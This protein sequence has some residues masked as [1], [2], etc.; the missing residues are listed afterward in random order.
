MFLKPIPLFIKITTIL[1]VCMRL[2]FNCLPVTEII[3]QALSPAVVQKVVTYV[4]KRMKRGQLTH[5]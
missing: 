1:F 4:A 2:Y 3:Q 5:I